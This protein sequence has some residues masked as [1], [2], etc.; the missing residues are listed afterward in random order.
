MATTLH[1][2][3]PI[4]STGDDGDA[5]SQRNSD[6][7]RSLTVS[8]KNY[9]DPDKFFDDEVLDELTV[10]IQ[11]KHMGE[12]VPGRR[13]RRLNETGSRLADVDTPQGNTGNDVG[14]RD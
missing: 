10:H 13:S 3:P 12:L 11:R 1:K 14:N 9:R 6:L 2:E 5:I 8:A 4:L 7:F